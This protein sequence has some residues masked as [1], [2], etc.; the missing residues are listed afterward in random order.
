[1]SMGP[2]P[3]EPSTEGKDLSGGFIQLRI[4]NGTYRHKCKVHVAPFTVSSGSLLY[5]TPPS[6]LFSDAGPDVTASGLIPLLQVYYSSDWTISLESIWQM[7]S[8]EPQQVFP[9]PV[10]AS[11]AGTGVQTAGLQWTPESQM[12]LTTRDDHGHPFRFVL[13][14][15]ANWAAYG[16]ATVQAVSGG[17]ADQKLVNFLASNGAI[18]SHAGN[19][20]LAPMTALFTINRRLRRAY[21]L[22]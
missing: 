1:M 5:N 10:V 12:T 4:S 21:H 9:T 11:A 19:K 7:V 20:V 8:G 22:G 16:P 3:P 13:L 2:T 18:R 15:R 14:S 17:T 6:G